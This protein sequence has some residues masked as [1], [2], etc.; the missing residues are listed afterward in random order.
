MNGK[1][2]GKEYFD[3]VRSALKDE[4]QKDTSSSSRPLKRRKTRQNTTS[5]PTSVNN[6]SKGTIDYDK[7]VDITQNVT[8]EVDLG[9]AQRLNKLKTK[10]EIQK[11]FTSPRKDEVIEILSSEE[12][13]EQRTFG[14]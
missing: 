4:T 5:L 11:H 13:Q 3:L 10:R 8:G 6:I 1:K 9:E 14:R 12:E 7:L 2:L